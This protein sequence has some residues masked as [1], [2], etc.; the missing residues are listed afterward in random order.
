MC[1]CSR[2]VRGKSKKTKGKIGKT[3]QHSSSAVAE[4][5][6]QQNINVSIR[7]TRQL[8][9]ARY[10]LSLALSLVDSRERDEALLLEFHSASKLSSSRKL[11]L[12]CRLQ[13]RN[14]KPNVKAVCVG[15][16]S[17]PP[18]KFQCTTPRGRATAQKHI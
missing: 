14:T 4:I 10:P 5:A 13:L 11:A 7:L 16:G 17:C 8:H 12:Q 3:K 18:A 2:A 6:S 9:P 15:A 1:V